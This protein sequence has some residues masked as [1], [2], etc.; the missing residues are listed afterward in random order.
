MLTQPQPM[1]GCLTLADGTRYA[2][3]LYG[4]RPDDRPLAAEV[5]FTTAMG[6]YPEAI[7]DPSYQDQILVLAYPQAGIYGVPAEAVQSRAA[8][9]R[10]LVV[11]DL[12]PPP[13]AVEALDAFLARQGVPLLAGVDTRALI[14][15]LRSRG[16]TL[17]TVAAGSDGVPPD[18]AHSARPDPLRAAGERARPSDPTTADRPLRVTVVDLGAKRAV[19]EMLAGQEGVSVRTV[20]TDADPEAVARDCD[21][22]LFSNGP[23]D[24][25][26]MGGLLPFVRNLAERRPTFGICLGHQLLAEAFGAHTFKLAF[27]HRGVNHPV[28][29]LD[30]GHT[31]ITSHNHGYA[32]A[33]EDLPA[34]LEVTARDL[35]DRTVEGLRHRRLPI[36]SLQFHPEGS[37]GPREADIAL[38]AFLADVR[39]GGR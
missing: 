38:T 21:A 18:P 17:G 6:G 22:V 12:A 36:V 2:G 13:D 26:D 31:W 8:M 10:A 35:T 27:G 39:E 20:T 1:D 30:S 29:H 4:A 7:T 24:P 19:L 11:R 33:E 25:A 3:V 16:T 32:V 37:P 15:R 5:V 28:R 14:R 23:G 34:E 9:I